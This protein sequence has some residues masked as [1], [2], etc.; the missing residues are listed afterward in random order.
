MATYMGKYTSAVCIPCTITLIS[1]TYTTDAYGQNVATESTKD[2]QGYIASV[3]A[4]ENERAAQNGL[5]AAWEATFWA[6]EY[7]EEMAVEVNGKR[8]SVYRFY[9]RSDGRVELY[10]GKRAGVINGKGN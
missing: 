2:V 7:N 9:Y 8:Y 6:F 5:I 10:L 3:S 1:S 4:N